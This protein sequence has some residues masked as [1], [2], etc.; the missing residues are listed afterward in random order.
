MQK[1]E[2]IHFRIEAENKIRLRQLAESTGRDQSELAR[3]AFQQYLD[4]QEWQINGIHEA[5]AAAD[6]SEFADDA[7]IEAI[8]DKYTK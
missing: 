6:R 8:F 5:L 7:D 4:I 1:L 2:A 3:E